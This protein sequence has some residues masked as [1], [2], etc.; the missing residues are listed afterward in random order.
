MR[1]PNLYV[2]STHC[3]A[4]EQQPRNLLINSFDI[5][6]KTIEDLASGSDVPPTGC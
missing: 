1:T 5:L 4:K 2:L 6:A 3:E